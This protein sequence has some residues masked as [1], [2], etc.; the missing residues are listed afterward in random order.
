MASRVEP[1][2]AA[3]ALSDAR[4]VAVDGL[5]AAAAEQPAE[6]WVRGRSSRGTEGQHL[7]PYGSMMYMMYMMC[8]MY[9]SV[10][11]HSTFPKRL[12]HEFEG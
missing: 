7:N 5:V 11:K 9:Q 1:A 10:L 8:M 3:T 12:P 2:V 6:K 4:V